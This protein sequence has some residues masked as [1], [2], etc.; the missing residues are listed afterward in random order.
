[1][2]CAK[3]RLDFGVAFIVVCKSPTRIQARDIFHGSQA[4][5]MAKIR[6]EYIGTP[7]FDPA[8]VANASSAA[9]GLCRWVLAMEVYD[10]IAKI[11]APKK[12]KLAEARAELAATMAQLELKRAELKASEERLKAL[13]KSLTERTENKAKLE[14]QVG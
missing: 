6:K 4:A 1:M 11:V 9:E 14:A 8:K 10:R 2:W 5:V 13:N 3:Y 12:A 7:E